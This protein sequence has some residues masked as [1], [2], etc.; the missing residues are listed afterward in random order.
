MSLLA[1][2]HKVSQSGNT[3]DAYRFMRL[4][5]AVQVKESDGL[6]ALTL[7]PVRDNLRY[8]LV[9]PRKGNEALRD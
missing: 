3:T 9:L 5:F 1:S 2:D 6:S 8:L 4:F 7:H